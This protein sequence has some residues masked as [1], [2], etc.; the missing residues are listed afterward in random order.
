LIIERDA[1]AQR[2][3]RNTHAAFSFCAT[4]HAIKRRIDG[5]A[6]KMLPPARVITPPPPLLSFDAR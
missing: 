1:M 5:D 3:M 6:Q 2:K 4:A